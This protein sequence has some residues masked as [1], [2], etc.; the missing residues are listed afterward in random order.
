MQRRHS[1]R[2][3][4]RKFQLNEIVIKILLT[5]FIPFDENNAFGMTVWPK[6]VDIVCTLKAHPNNFTIPGSTLNN[7]HLEFD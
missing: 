3:T 5:F 4:E 6:R 7:A 2:R 1:E